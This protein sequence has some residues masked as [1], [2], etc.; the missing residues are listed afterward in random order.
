MTETKSSEGL[1]GRFVHKHLEA[2][3]LEYYP[4]HR[5]VNTQG[6]I[7]SVFSRDQYGTPN[8]YEV[9]WFSAL[10]G[11]PLNSEVVLAELMLFENWSF[12]E[13][14]DVWIQKFEESIELYR[15]NAERQRQKEQ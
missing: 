11:Y 14:R 6:F 15:I 5:Y 12:Y 3:Y 8:A 9:E 4:K 2:G 13:D 7:K 10:S 1:V